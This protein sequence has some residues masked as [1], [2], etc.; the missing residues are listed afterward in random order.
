MAAAT[1]ERVTEQLHAWL[2]AEPS[3]TGR[4]LI[5]RRQAAR[6]AEYS[7]GL[8]RTVHHR[9]KIWRKK[10]AM[11]MVFG[12]L[13]KLPTEESVAGTGKKGLPRPYVPASRELV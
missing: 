9:V 2:E 10:K 4:Q 7:D 8:L 3:C 12:T 5:E 1:R 11:A 6:P 13:G